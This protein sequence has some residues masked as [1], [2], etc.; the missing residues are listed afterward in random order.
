MGVIKFKLFDAHEKRVVKESL[1]ILRRDPRG[2]EYL[3]LFKLTSD[4]NY[5]L[6][7]D[8]SYKETDD[9][10]TVKYIASRI[11]NFA[12]V[13]Y[14]SAISGYYQVSFSLMRE[15]IES[16]FLLDFF[17]SNRSEITKWKNADDKTR[18]NY[19]SPNNLYKMLDQRDNFT[20]E[21]R[22]KQYQM[23]CENAAHVSYKGFK[24]LTNTDNKVETGF[25]L[26]EKKLIN[27]FAELSRR[28]S[29]VVISLITLLTTNST[30]TLDAEIKFLKQFQKLWGDEKL[31]VSNEK[32]VKALNKYK[33]QLKHSQVQTSTKHLLTSSA[34]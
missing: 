20:G 28:Y 24:L 29:A 23:F 4:L 26:D 22:K 6:V 19:F 9:Q 27:A 18:K 17:R 2:K 11:F 14:R 7:K 8:F 13:S 12:I 30:D 5:S 10:L 15:F 31:Q 33:G 16:Q 1:A 25:F 3:K 21:Q 34:M 32:L